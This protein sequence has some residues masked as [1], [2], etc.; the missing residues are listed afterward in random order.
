[1][2]S[3]LGKMGWIANNFVGGEVRRFLV[4][5]VAGRAACFCYV[6]TL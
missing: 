1:M 5:F 4:A 2:G 3:I 6:E